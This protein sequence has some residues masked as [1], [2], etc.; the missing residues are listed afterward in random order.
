MAYHTARYFLIFLPLVVLLY[1]LAPK[2]V[3]PYIL[4]AA[5]YILF[6]SFSRWLVLILVATTLI[7]YGFGRILGSLKDKHAELI[8]TIPKEEKKA[9][10]AKYKKQEKKVLIIGIGILLF[11]LIILKYTDFILQNAGKLAHANWHAPGFMKFLVPIGISFY[12]LEAIGYLAD[13]Y[14]GKVK[15]EKNFMKLSLFMSFF[16]QVMEGPIAMY[17]QTADDLWAGR[18]ITLENLSNGLR[19]IVWG[20]FKKIVIADRI[21]VIVTAIYDTPINTLGDSWTLAYSALSSQSADIILNTMHATNLT[22]DANLA[23]QLASG[24][25]PTYHGM[26]IL[27]AAVAY[28]VQLFMEFS[29]G[30]D[31]IV[32]SGMIFGVNLP[33]NFERPF[34]AK[35]AGEFWRRWHISLGAWLKTYVFY[36]MSV[37]ELAKKWG[38]FAKSLGSKTSDAAKS[39]STVDNNTITKTATTDSKGDKKPIN[40]KYINK[41]GVSAIS[42]F[43]VWLING[44][45]HGPHWN[46]I[47]YGMYYFAILLFMIIVEPVTAGLE[48]LFCGGNDD[49]RDGPAGS[50]A[51]LSTAKKSLGTVTWTLLNILKTWCI[52]F[53]GE[54]FFRSN[55]LKHGFVMLRAM[56]VDFNFK[57][58]TDGTFSQ[59]FLNKGDYIA[60]VVGTIIVMIAGLLKEYGIIKDDTFWHMK[61]PVRWAI[62]YA[63]II[64]VVMF[65]AYGTGYQTVDLIYAGF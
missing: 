21:Y 3:R 47:F 52:I 50:V 41:V 51:K 40:T 60:I 28:T 62:Y 54:L 57:A 55:S 19:R 35:D 4:L 39:D 61:L 15:A 27:V 38:R 65:G 34:L 25:I 22:Q 43:P 13:V 46:Y 23:A 49:H 53:V 58:F 64:A 29:G 30:M 7:V 6:F 59:F 36:P 42:L 18:G 48:R 31:I 32:G 11:V 44:L 5:S 1:Q 26:M 63:M 17:E 8:K 10:K 33:E 56:C 12:T 14:W 45:W 37:S 16:P 9:T 2:K 20:L 24:S